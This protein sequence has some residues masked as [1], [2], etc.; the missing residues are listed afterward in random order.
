MR[1]L[2]DDGPH[3]IVHIHDTISDWADPAQSMDGH[4]HPLSRGP[5]PE[6]WWSIDMTPRGW[7]DKVPSIPNVGRNGTGWMDGSSSRTPVSCWLLA[8]WRQLGVK[9]GRKT[10]DSAAAV[11]YD[12]LRCNAVW[13]GAVRGGRELIWFFSNKEITVGDKINM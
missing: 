5:G 9:K 10:F 13:W 4:G 12:Y 6:R 1:W 11:M 7:F 2:P 3:K 8:N